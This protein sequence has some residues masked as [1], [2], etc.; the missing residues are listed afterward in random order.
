MVVF[1]TDLAAVAILIGSDWGVHWI[2]V[3]LEHILGKSISIDSISH[4]LTDKFVTELRHG[5]MHAQEHNINRARAL[6]P[7]WAC[8]AGGALGRNI[9]DDVHF[10]VQQRRDRHL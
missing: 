2:G 4:G 10:P 8:D 5:V 3:A 9:G 1:G 7:R 6:D